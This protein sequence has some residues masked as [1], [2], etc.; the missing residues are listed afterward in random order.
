M[1]LKYSIK[2]TFK[3]ITKCSVN[4]EQQN[5]TIEI[6]E[7]TRERVGERDSIFVKGS[8][9]ATIKPANG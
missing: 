4:D 7:G 9:T 2:L 8:E 3:S 1:H 5:T 6:M